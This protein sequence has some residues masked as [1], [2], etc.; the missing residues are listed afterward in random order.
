MSVFPC[1]NLACSQDHS[2]LRSE[3]FYFSF[4]SHNLTSN[5]LKLIMSPTLHIYDHHPLL[6]LDLYHRLLSFLMYWV[7]GGRS[8]FLPFFIISQSFPTVHANYCSVITTLLSTVF[9]E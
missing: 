8:L 5:Y 7:G 6:L 9:R 2:Y 1:L 4:F 3:K